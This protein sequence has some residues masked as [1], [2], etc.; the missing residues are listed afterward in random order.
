M[1]FSFS[2]I[3][4]PLGEILARRRDPVFIFILE[5]PETTYNT[6]PYPCKAHYFMEGKQFTRHPIMESKEAFKIHPMLGAQKIKDGQ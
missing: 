6:L 2:I 3:V 4:V 5:L 1:A